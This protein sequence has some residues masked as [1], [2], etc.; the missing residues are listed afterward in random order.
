[1]VPGLEGPNPEPSGFVRVF[2]A[3]GTEATQGL[4]VPPD[5]E[6]LDRPETGADQPP[7]PPA[8]PREF[9]ARARPRRYLRA[10][11]LSRCLRDPR[12][13]TRMTDMPR[14]RS[15]AAVGGG[16]S[17]QAQG[18]GARTSMTSLCDPAGGTV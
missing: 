18:R 1:M 5:E 13:K 16:G 14:P 9:S 6:G 8:P 17:E 3:R 2:P 15:P 10:L 12:T 7:P 11:A 4:F